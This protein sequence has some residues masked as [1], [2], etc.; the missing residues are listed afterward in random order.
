LGAA[1]D[2]LRR[3][4]RATRESEERMEFAAASAN[5]GLWYFAPSSG[6]MWMTEHCRSMLGLAAEAPLTSAAVQ[7]VIHPDDRQAVVDST[8]L[9]AYAG[10][11]G[12][13]EFRVGLPHS[14]V[15][16]LRTHAQ[17]DR[18]ESG[19]PFRISGVFTDMTAAKAAEHEAA[20]QR[21]ELAHLMRVSAAGE[22]SGAIAHEINQPLTAILS[23]AQAARLMLA[24]QRPELA[25]VG[26]AID[27]IVHEGKRAGDVIERLRGLLKKGES[28][29]E[30]IDLNELIESTL[31]LL[32]SELIG[33]RVRVARKL[34]RDLPPLYGDPV[35]V[36]QVLLNLVMNA[37]DAMSATL[38]G[39][40]MV[41]ITTR[42]TDKDEAEIIVADR[43]HGLQPADHAK[44]F[45][46]FFTTKVHGLGLGLSICSTIVTAHGG[47][48]KLVNDPDG[49]ARA[50]FT[51]PH[52]RIAMA[53]K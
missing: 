49:G 2:Q 40:R 3:A 53:A 46:P 44:V 7:A 24:D 22:L 29:L 10:K 13:G 12:V 23:N 52:H 32:H 34:A 18:D 1:I 41:T 27:D 33:R 28:R 36:Q 11:E 25:D 14:Q 8:R 17:A 16:W 51:L 47:Q 5:I 20:R 31:Q 38:V 6:E 30:P 35:Q 45:E 39:G 43:G 15:R 37:M 26:E 48:L 4:E 42:H 50:S 19:R 9:A 21:S